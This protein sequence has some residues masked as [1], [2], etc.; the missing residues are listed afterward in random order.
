MPLP[1]RFDIPTLLIRMETSRSEIDFMIVSTNPSFEMISP[2]SHL[3]TLNCAFGYFLVTSSTTPFAFYS[4][5]A[6]KITLNPLLANEKQNDLPIPSVG[7][8]TIAQEFSPYRFCKDREGRKRLN[9]K[10]RNCHNRLST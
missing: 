7:P 3:T 10:L 1:L 2:N 8:V 5:L 9:K 4:F 6:T